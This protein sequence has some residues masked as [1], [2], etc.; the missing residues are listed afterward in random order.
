MHTPTGYFF[1]FF[2]EKNELLVKETDN[3][4]YL[5]RIK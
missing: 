4:Y 2:P 3:I 1:E 5:K